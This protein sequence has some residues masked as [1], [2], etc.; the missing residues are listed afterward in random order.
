MVARL[1]V[2]LAFLI[3]GQATTLPPLTPGEVLLKASSTDEA[4]RAD[5]VAALKNED[6]LVRAARSAGLD[7]DVAGLLA[8]SP[9]E[10]EPARQDGR[11]IVVRMTVTVNFTIQ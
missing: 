6:T 3:T 1:L 2:A 4:V 10:F 8:I 5:V 7:L 11:P 9:W